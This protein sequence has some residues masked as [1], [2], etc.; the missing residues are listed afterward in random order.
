[1]SN[2]PTIQQTKLNKEQHSAVTHKNGILLVCAGAGSGKT[3]V[4]TMRIAHLIVNNQVDPLSI[5]ALTFT[6]KAAKEMRQR[7]QK[8][9]GEG[10][11]S[12]PFVGTF[13]SYCL[14]LLKTNRV[15]P[16]LASYSI[17]DQDDK[18]LLIKQLVKHRGLEKQ[19]KTKS[20]SAYISAKKNRADIQEWTYNPWYSSLEEVAKQYEEEKE[21]CRALDFDDLLVRALDLF[22]KY[23][24]FKQGFQCNISHV[25]VD[26]YQDTNAI[27]HELLKEMTLDTK[28]KFVADSLCVVGDEDQSIYSWRGATVANILNFEKDF[29]KTNRIT[30][31]QNYRSVQPIL[32]AANSVI[33]NNTMRNPKDLWS[34]KEARNRLMQ[35]TCLSNYQEADAV[36]SFAT[37]V[38]RFNEGS[39]IAVLYRSHYQSRTL[40]EA[41]IKSS[42]PYVIIGG[43]QFYERKEIKDM[44]AY[45]RLIANPFDRISFSRII[46]TPLRGLGAK[47]KELFSATWAQN[48]LY[49]SWQVAQ[50]MIDQGMV[51]HSKKKALQKV[52]DLFTGLDAKSPVHA[53]AQNILQSIGYYEYLQD[54]CEPDVARTRTENMHELLGAI[55]HFEQQGHT[56][57]QAFLDEVA[58]LQ[59][60]TLKN[61][62]NQTTPTVQMMTLHAAKGLE[63]DNVILVGLEEG[64]LP[65]SRSIH[66][67]QSVEEE[68]RLVY[69]GITRARER[70][71]L[72]NAR[73][74]TTYGQMNEQLPSRFL[75]EVPEQLVKKHECFGWTRGNF[76]S[77]FANWL[78]GMP[79]NDFT[80]EPLQTEQPWQAPQTGRKKPKSPQ[81]VQRSAPRQIQ[82]SIPRPKRVASTKTGWAIRQ[83]VTHAVFGQGDITHIDERAD[84]SAR[85]TI[86]FAIGIKVIDEKFIR[87]A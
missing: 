58:L 14:R 66:D 45:M 16:E 9:V 35:L 49:N 42:I 11:I 5:V 83:Q 73:Y 63:F 50:L 18:E 79:S 77:Q 41:L 39:S 85:L 53:T 74:R 55:A 19:L 10:N 17:M 3:R 60:H 38:K 65:S 29:K 75:D 2:Q 21:L 13:H 20:V 24:A 23:P 69:V 62:E 32:E 22:K 72:T 76:S 68:R 81:A 43:I 47:F 12:R 87:K 71:L 25:L 27:Q 59:E 70:V 84:G 1:V 56:T 80:V 64:L 37:H 46:N 78:G 67:E 48:S 57:I 28:K 8:L 82:H 31:S 15:M 34:S 54:Q 7:V 51:T 44:L 6:N 61:K 40:E 30:I 4:I 36:A 86:A 26:E 33:S 52:V